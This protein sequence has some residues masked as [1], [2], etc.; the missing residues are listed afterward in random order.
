MKSQQPQHP[1]SGGTTYVTSPRQCVRGTVQSVDPLARELAVLSPA[2]CEV[3]YVPPDCPTYLRGERIK[4][5]MAQSGDAVRVTFALE[6]SVLMVALLE[7]WPDA[8]YPVPGRMQNVLPTA[9]KTLTR[10]PLA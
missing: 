4:L 2:G 8:D 9:D 6:G 1:T 5:R 7:I 3:F 10:S